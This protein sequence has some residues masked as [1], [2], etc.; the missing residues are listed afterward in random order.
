[1]K[2]KLEGCTKPVSQ[3]P[4]GVMLKFAKLARGSDSRRELPGMRVAVLP[5]C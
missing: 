3:L 2:L 1:M 5:K 4:D